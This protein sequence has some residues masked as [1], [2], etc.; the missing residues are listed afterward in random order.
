[1]YLFR[2]IDF[3]YIDG[4]HSASDVLLDAAMSFRLLRRGGVMVFDDYDSDNR[5]PE[6]IE[7]KAGIDAFIATHVGQLKI[8]YQTY[9]VVVVKQ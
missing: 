3:V 6:S 1:M 2:Q 7:T 5:R 8:V 4:G 9:I